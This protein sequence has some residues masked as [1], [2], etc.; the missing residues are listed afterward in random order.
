M[1]VA[2]VAAKNHPSAGGGVGRSGNLLF[3]VASLG[4]FQGIGIGSNKKVRLFAAKLA[5]AV[6]AL[7]DGGRQLKWTKAPSSF[8]E[9]LAEA[10]Q[11]RHSGACVHPDRA[12]STSSNVH[13][14]ARPKRL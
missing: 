1:R 6:A 8:T 3:A 13:E 14:E 7:V 11:L 5:V 9:L 4:G 12:A 2:L 10:Q